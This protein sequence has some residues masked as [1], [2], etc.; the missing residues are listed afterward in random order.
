MPCVGAHLSNSSYEAE[1][2]PKTGT[3]FMTSIFKDDR[4]GGEPHV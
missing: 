2:V 1:D 3:P 4:E